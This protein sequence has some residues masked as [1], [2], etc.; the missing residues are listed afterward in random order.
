MNNNPIIITG[1]G[2]SG[3]RVIVKILSFFDFNFGNDLNRANDDLLFTLIFKLPRHY[4]KYFLKKD[5]YVL[6]NLKLYNKIKHNKKL[7]IREKTTLAKLGLLHVTQFKHYNFSW[8]FKRFWKILLNRQKVDTL[9]GWKEPH[10]LFFLDELSDFYSNPK[11]ILIIRNGLDMV[12]S[13]TDQQFYNYAEYFDLN[14]GNDS[15][16]NKFEFWYRANSYAINLAEKKYGSNYKIIFYEDIVNDSKNNIIEIGS[17]LKA[18]I[19]DESLDNLLNQIKNPGT[20]YRFKEHNMDWI[21]SDIMEKLE[22]I[23]YDSHKLGLNW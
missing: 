17:F 14:P 18:E 21:T 12:Y 19:D 7:S 22:K 15:L 1:I 20:M 10:N 16:K 5:D 3:T 13:N 4:K 2:G 6:D 8:V 9:W 11:V 23:G